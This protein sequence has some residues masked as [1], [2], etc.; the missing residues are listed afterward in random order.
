M[1]RRVEWEQENSG[2]ESDDSVSL[3]FA[4]SRAARKSANRGKSRGRGRGRATKPSGQRGGAGGGVELV[5][6]PLS[7]VIRIAR[8]L[9][10]GIFWS[11]L[12]PL[13]Q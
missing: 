11:T 13:K 6:G 7:L 5:L 10:T 2:M 1:M 4:S 9:P 3:E 12:L 8:M